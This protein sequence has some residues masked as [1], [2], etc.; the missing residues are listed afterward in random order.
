MHTE[1][2]DS[3]RRDRVGGPSAALARATKH[4]LD[5]LD[6]PMNRS[7]HARTRAPR[8][9][10]ILIALVTI[11][12]LSAAVVEFAYASRV[13]LSMAS[14]ERDELKSYFMARSAMNITQLLLS[15]QFAL[16]K[17]SGNTDDAMGQLISR[18]IRRSN[19]QIYQYVDLLMKPFHSGKVETPVGGIDLEESGVEGFGNFTGEF[20]SVVTPEA[21]KINLNEFYR[22]KIDENDLIQLCSML[23]DPSYD[24][25]F[26]QKDASGETMSRKVIVENIV[27]FIDPDNQS[28]ALDQDCRIQGA[29][30]DETL[31]YDRDDRSNVE[32]RDALLT[33]PEDL[34]QV[35]GVGQAFMDN[36]G[37]KFTVYNVG[38]PNINVAT[39]PV[40][41]SIL[42]RTVEIGTGAP[43]SGYNL[44]SRNPAVSE[45]VL[46]LSM[47]LDGIRTFFEDPI[48]VLLAYV[49]SNESRLLPSAKRGQPVAFLNTGQLPRFV[50]DLQENPIIMAQFLQYSAFYQQM[51][52]LRPERAVD[53]A[54]P[55]FPQWTVAFDRG[56]LAREVSTATPQIYRVVSTGRYGTTESTIEA[57]IDLGKTMRRLPTERQLL[58]DADDD[59]AAKELKALLRQE[60][61]IMPKGRI[62]YWREN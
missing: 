60:Q 48:S 58:D 55:N 57:V 24:D 14:N 26:S 56:K 7:N 15:L 31:S 20:S 19:F 21:G 41:Y 46:W 30:G 5:R 38:K 54:A 33:H 36:F 62:L 16:Q 4:T 13:N 50:K 49:G 28:I 32:P 44:C 45:Q 42:C 8:G 53:P 29:G 59:E 37:D 18:A 3:A 22:E 39:A 23:V 6:R 43:T 40:F 25:L 51:V 27:D 1:S 34:H 35:Y 61:D 9:V 12:I 47:A 11:T 17:E 10:A 52:A 2:H